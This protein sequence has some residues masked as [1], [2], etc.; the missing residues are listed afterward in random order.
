MD[1][2]GIFAV[3]LTPT[4]ELATQ[5]SDQFTAFGR[6]V[7]LQLCTV[8]GGRDLVDLGNALSKYVCIFLVP[9]MSWFQEAP[10]CRRNSWSIG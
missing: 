9:L 4:R 8:T 2:Y 10:Y 6:P 3:I 1:P 5:I 7:N